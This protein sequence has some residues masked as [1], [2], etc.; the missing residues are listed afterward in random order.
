MSKRILLMLAAAFLPLSAA[1]VA[2]PVPALAGSVPALDA[3]VRCSAAFGIVAG[4]QRR[5]VP[6]ALRYPPLGQ[7]GREFFVLTGARLMDAEHLTRDA[8]QAR[9]GAEVERL[10]A[11]TARAP[12]PAAALASVMDPCLKL[13]DAALPAPGN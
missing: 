12:D 2:A 5:G 7:R 3:A 6:D 13:L 4:Q 8:M 1:A 10:Q 9:I 11:E